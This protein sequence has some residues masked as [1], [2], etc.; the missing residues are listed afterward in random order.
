M[1]QKKTPALCPLFYVL[2]LTFSFNTILSCGAGEGKGQARLETRSYHF[3]TADGRLIPIRA[4]RAQTEAERAAGLMWRKTLNDGDGMLFIYDRDQILSFWM[5]NT[6]LPLSIAFIAADGR[7]LE[8]RDMTPQSLNSI[9]SQRS[10]R[11]A[12]EVPQGW[13]ERAGIA[14]GDRLLLD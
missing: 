6:L 9:S 14:A 2:L 3:Q 7:L 5:K 8:T 1:R 11:Y 4:E 10:A 12:L 13:F